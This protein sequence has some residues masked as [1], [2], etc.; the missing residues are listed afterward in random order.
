MST[1]PV[2]EKLVNFL[3]TASHDYAAATLAGTT[4]AMPPTIC[5]IGDEEIRPSG[6]MPVDVI[7]C[8]W[9]N[10]QEKKEM[11]MKVG[12]RIA[13]NGAR[14]WSFLSEAWTA[15][16]TPE[17][18]KAHKV[19]VRPADRPDRR[20][21]VFCMVGFGSEHP[22]KLWAWNIIREAGEESKCLK[23]ESGVNGEPGIQSWIAVLLNAAIDFHILMGP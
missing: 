10:D 23:L 2:D 19:N 5:V 18:R 17:E 1:Q 22:V 7:V 16:A 9:A 20:E 15:T 4:K 21:T 14:A 3:A 13:S 8:P 11:V 12:K 6:D